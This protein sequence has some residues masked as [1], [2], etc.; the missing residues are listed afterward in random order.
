MITFSPTRGN[1]DVISS[2]KIQSYQFYLMFAP[3][4]V[5]RP[6]HFRLGS[7]GGSMGV[8]YHLSFH[9]LSYGKTPSYPNKRVVHSFKIAFHSFALKYSDRSHPASTYGYEQLS[10]MGHA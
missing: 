8:H 6:E 2:H 9:L 10:L 3:I 4:K 1:S 5:P 7:L